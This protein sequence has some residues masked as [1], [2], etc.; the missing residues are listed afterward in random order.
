MVL[1]TEYTPYGEPARNRLE[2]LIHEH[3][4]NDPLQ[5]V[6]VVVPTN[7]AGVATRRAL[8]AKK[9]GI[10]AVHFLK[11]FDLAERLANPTNQKPLPDPVLS[12]TLR[13]VLDADPGLFQAS[14]RHPAT[15][16]AL[17]QAYR[18]LRNLT[19]EQLD[20]LATQSRRA[21]DMVRVCRQARDRLKG[22]WYDG[23]DLNE[24]SITALESGA[25]SPILKEL[26]PAIIYLPQ[27]VTHSQGC[28]VSALAKKTPV[29][30]I[31]GLTG[32][33]GADT[34]VLESV[35]NMGGELNVGV[36]IN[37]PH[38][39]WI[40]STTSADEEVQVAVREVLNATR[41]GIALNRIAVL[42]GGG[43][44]TIRH[45]QDHL[46][47]AGIPFNGPS[48]LTLAESLVGR[49]LLALLNLQDRDFRRDE[50]FNLL[51]VVEPFTTVPTQISAQTWPR[52]IPVTAWDRIAR[53]AGVV[54]SADQWRER[55]EAHYQKLQQAAEQKK[56][57]PDEIESWAEWNRREINHTNSLIEFMAELIG[58][59]SP[60][61]EPATWKAWCKWIKGLIDKYL[62]GDR[63]RSGWPEAEQEAA[64]Q[65]ESI[66]DSFTNLDR[67]EPSPRPAAFRHA[68][69]SELAAPTKRAG[70]IGQ[71]VLT[72]QIGGSTGMEQDRT[73]LIGLAEGT[74]PHSPSDNPLLPDRERKAV[75]DNLTLLSDR[76]EEQHR[77]FLTV[78]A[79]SATSTL[80]YARGNSRQAC[81]Q[82]P[83]RWLLDTATALAGKPVDSTNL[84]TP[85]V[86]RTIGWFEHVP[87]FSERVL[88]ADFPT[89]AQEFRLRAITR[90]NRA[91]QPLNQQPA[92]PAA[93]TNRTEQPL[94]QQPANLNTT[95]AAVANRT[96]YDLLEND[97]VLARGAELVAARS[98]NQFT[99][100]DGNLAGVDTTGLIGG[101][102]SPTSLETW[103]DCPMRYLFQ[104]VLGV[105]EADQPEEVLG[106]S[107]LDKGSLIHNALDLFLRE[108]METGQVPPPCQPWN[109]DQRER[110]RAI[111]TEQC[112]QAEAR[113]LTGYS[114]FW[115]YER[116]QIL[117]DLDRF[118]TADDEHRGQENV[119]PAASEL[120]FGTP[121]DDL[122]AITVELPRGQKA[123]F[124]GRAD[125]VDEGR[126][127][128]LVVIDY[129]TGR[130][131]G[132]RGLNESSAN[133]DPVQRGTRLQLPVYGLAARAHTEHSE[134][135]VAARYWFV[136]SEARFKTVGYPMDGT[137]MD[138]F[139]SVVGT[140]TEGIEAGVFCDRPRPDSSGGQ[141]SQRCGYCNADRLGTG[142]RR[143]QW[144]TMREREELAAYRQLAEPPEDSEQEE[145]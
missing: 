92:A 33:A 58:D 120:G 127:G 63:A 121:D 43:M 20:V 104:H 14:A 115:H 55:L 48:G 67:I 1:R 101:L 50:V 26:G 77:H 61:P 110:L 138:R 82:H 69:I 83:S 73:I 11:L 122:D 76:L 18:D 118:L 95:P 100:F 29:A 53:R 15:E 88:R 99:R 54:R 74:F 41:E 135:P 44:P 57:D 46:E 116:N 45:L 79:S 96:A 131:D 16:Q 117:K 134:A 23:Q 126:S 6:T 86:D 34:A 39:E 137:V 144:E 128:K 143:R 5:T 22:E 4:S 108:Q 103:A 2:T 141:Y 119:T 80:V 94:N 133:R 35:N 75:S 113:G 142:D 125:R 8:G 124:R 132:Y 40:I 123:R 31:A 17:V 109:T 7:M 107:A 28:M 9:P 102:V 72:E 91:G 106:I 21:A 111:G 66:L 38:G 105:Q 112:D 10:A 97:P 140:I 12:A 71:G 19:N 47:A 64:D 87:S 56:G 130:A 36:E 93:V 98:S 60:D 3:K 27:R 68:L 42:S 70:R 25:I 49:G 129:K 81:E 37:Q 24:L 51:S 145:Q 62:T 139:A 13:S 136:T 90:A 84:E 65:I 32:N 89:T 52:A 85:A 78:L 114:V 30:V 59:L